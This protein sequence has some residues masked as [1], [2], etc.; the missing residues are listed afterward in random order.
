M[1]QKYEKRNLAIFRKYLRKSIKIPFKDLALLTYDMAVKVD[2]NEVANA[3]RMLYLETGIRH[4]KKIGRAIQK[5]LNQEK[6]FNV[7]T[8]ELAYRDFIARW[9]VT[10]AGSR[11]ISVS[12][13]LKEYIINYI[14]ESAKEGKDIQTI[15]RELQKLIKSRRFY[16][17]QIMRIV[18]T[19][20]TAAANQGV[21]RAGYSTSIVWEKEWIS[22][23]DS[24]TRRRPDSQFD[25]YEMNGVRVAKDAK[26]NVN[27]DLVDYPADPKGQ[28]G[29]SINCRCGM[30]VVP[31][32]DANG[33][34]ILLNR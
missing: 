33:R 4:G 29:N 9:I 15:S 6:N 18:R 16:R 22:S 23:R 11:I 17:W 24:R 3:Y 32:R 26:F 7:D 12:E 14:A 5:E 8:F 34:I 20:T 1:H 28:A 30:A 21:L 27:G 10:E 2:V 31:K 13:E 25:H 19:E